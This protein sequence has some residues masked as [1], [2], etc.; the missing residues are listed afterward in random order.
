MSSR[1]VVAV[2]GSVVAVL[3]AAC[4]GGDGGD[5]GGSDGPLTLEDLRAT[6]DD[7]PVELEGAE[8]G[9]ELPTANG[10]LE[11]EATGDVVV[12]VDEHPSGDPVQGLDS[13]GGVYVECTL[14]LNLDAIVAIVY[15]SDQPVATDLASFEMRLR[16]SLLHR[17]RDAP[18][19]SELFTA[20]PEGELLDL[21]QDAPIAIA[22]LHVEG[23]ESA[24]LIIEVPV[25]VAYEDARAIAESA[26]ASL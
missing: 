9:I 17:D 20:T 10:D 21:D 5:G 19:V 7:C 6:G 24:V 23:A 2:V 4:G 3:L 14:P 22:R 1:W 11:L 8:E 16:A 26:L 18:T 12:A 25:M 15:A 13:A